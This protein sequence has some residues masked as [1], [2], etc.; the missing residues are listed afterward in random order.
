MAKVKLVRGGQE[1]ETSRQMGRL[2]YL[3]WF[4]KVELKQY[5]TATMGSARVSVADMVE[6]ISPTD[7]RR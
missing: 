1:P 4:L 3:V 2:S 6:S 5:P 7:T